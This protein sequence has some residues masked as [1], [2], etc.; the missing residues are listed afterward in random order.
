MF[1]SFDRIFLSR[2]RYSHDLSFNGSLFSIVNNN[3][4]AVIVAICC[5]VTSAVGW[6]MQYHAIH[7]ITDL[8]A[9]TNDTQQPYILFLN[10]MMVTIGYVGFG[11]PVTP[12][13]LSLVFF[14]TAFVTSRVASGAL[15]WMERTGMLVTLLATACEYFYRSKWCGCKRD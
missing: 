9:K 2:D 10:A 15:A 14:L 4:G 3:G 7:D 5:I 11:L 6:L 12:M 8:K 13:A 1:T